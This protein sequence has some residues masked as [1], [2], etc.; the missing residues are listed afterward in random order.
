MKHAQCGCIFLSVFFPAEYTDCGAKN[1]EIQSCEENAG[2]REECQ[3]SSRGCERYVQVV[4]VIAQGGIFVFY[5]GAP[6]IK[7]VWKD[8]DNSCA[9][10]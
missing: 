1:L 4:T 6:N 10:C 2:G 3:N 5:R 7:F 9:K 8:I